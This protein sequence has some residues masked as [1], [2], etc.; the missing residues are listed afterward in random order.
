M[1][2][3]F[4]LKTLIFVTGLIL[5]TLIVFY[6][7][8]INSQSTQVNSQSFIKWVDFNVPYTAMERALKYD[9]ESY[10]KDIRLNWIDLLSYLGAKY[11]GNFSIYKSKDLDFLVE[12]I[13]SGETIHDLT[14]KMKYYDYYHEVYSAVLSGFVGE[15]RIE[16][17]K[18]KDS[19]EK[20]WQSKYGLEAFLPIASGYGFSH[21]DDFGDQRSYGYKRRH[22]G[23]DLMGSVGTP[24]VAV[25]SGYVEALGWDEFGGWRIGIRSFDKKRYFYYAHLRKDYPYHG[26]LYIGKTVKAGDV[27]GYM[28]MTGYSTRENVNNIKIP[29]LHF[30]MQLIFD[31]SQKDGANEIWINVYN[32]IELLRKN[33]VPVYKDSETEDFYRTFDI[34]L[35]ETQEVVN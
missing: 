1:I 19:D 29:H 22:L 26:D 31:E 18:S 12:R 3:I 25:E 8:G 17:K 10:G 21:Y 27:I 28:G 9:I 34:K 11:G 20:I 35:S 15:Y 23:N 24:I 5:I 6:T 33:S 32:I 2:I 13:N 14:G 30:G 4:R 7:F 16:V